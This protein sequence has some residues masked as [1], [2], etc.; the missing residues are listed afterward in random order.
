MA[1]WELA[2]GEWRR[3][4]RYFWG[5]ANLI[6]SAL[7]V[8]LAILT[9]TLVAER[10]GAA[11]P[12]LAPLPLLV[13]ASLVVGP[14]TA[15]VGRWLGTGAMETLFDRPEPAGPA[16]PLA[17]AAAL[18]GL[19]LQPAGL[20]VGLLAGQGLILLSHN[21]ILALAWPFV[22]G[23]LG[24]DSRL[25]LGSGLL[26]LIA[27]LDSMALGVVV[28]LAAGRRHRLLGWAVWPLVVASGSLAPLP[29]WPPLWLWPPAGLVAAF[30]ALPAEGWAGPLTLAVVGSAVV[31]A[32]ALA[33]FSRAARRQGRRGDPAAE[34]G[35]GGG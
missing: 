13:G 35:S 21:L 27:A 34:A 30:Q 1:W 18:L 17:P 22:L 4:F 5:A 16:R 12:L 10:D 26:W 8:L 33:G 23:W 29:E 19:G 6:F 20:L 3:H 28:G 7:Y 31:W 9:V 24:A 11:F 15:A 14:A 32:V 25:W 2:L